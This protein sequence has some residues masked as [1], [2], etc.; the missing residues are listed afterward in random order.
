MGSIVVSSGS[1][2][3]TAT[4]VRNARL[5]AAA[6]SLIPVLLFLFSAALRLWQPDLVPFGSVQA[7]YVEAAEAAAPVSLWRLFIDPSHSGLA[8]MRVLLGDWAPVVLWIAARGLLDAAG[9]VFL[10]RAARPLVGVGGATVL[11]LLS[12][13]SWILWSA[14]RDPAGPLS[15]SVAAL[16]LWAAVALVRRPT[17]VGGGLF[18]LSL[19][20]L[21]RTDPFPWLPVVLG[22]AALAAGRASWRVGGVTAACMVLLAAPVLASMRDA[23]SLGEVIGGLFSPHRG[24]LLSL[25]PLLCLALATPLRLRQRAVQWFTWAVLSGLCGLSLVMT[26]MNMQAHEAAEWQRPIF[27]S[28]SLDA[29]SD[30]SVLDGSGALGSRPSLRE[31]TALAMGLREAA[32]RTAVREVTVLDA[33]TITMTE[34]VAFAMRHADLRK[35]ELPSDVSV[36]P[37]ERETVFLVSDRIR[38]AADSSWPAELRRPASSVQL[39][40][41]EGAPLG[42]TLLSLRPREVNH[43]LSKAT[44]IADGTFVDGSVLH[45]VSLDVVNKRLVLSTY[46][47]LPAQTPTAPLGER[48]RADLP[49]AATIPM[50][51]VLPAQVARE[52][53]ELTVLTMVLAIQA[54]AANAV[55]LDL[56]LLDAAG[57]TIPRTNGAPSLS[58]SIG[59][60]PR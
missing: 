15:A 1:L 42:L 46:W 49:R 36:L 54:G 17:L 31:V 45:G 60:P 43:W 52:Q 12:G 41:P 38:A 19:G 35:R 26:A 29:V 55:T 56:S 48:V 37:L 8:W 30:T 13:G 39:F 16:A 9:A 7:R 57:G 10:F 53:G 2:P 47:R 58:V 23:T 20:L 44:V 50:I 18:G 59:L 34:S 33:R 5:R 40:T 24:F 21:M 51:G 4:A 32:G 6:I 22:A 27:T 25:W 28:R 14:S 11:G 3:L